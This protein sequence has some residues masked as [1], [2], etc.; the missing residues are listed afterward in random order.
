MFLKVQSSS[1]FPHTTKKPWKVDHN[2]I[3]KC[4][5]VLKKK[6]D[7]AHLYNRCQTRDEWK[8]E[9][10]FYISQ[11]GPME[12]YKVPSNHMDLCEC[13][14]ALKEI[15]RKEKLKRDRFKSKKVCQ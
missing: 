7:L 3:C 11:N 1:W 10:D 14:V 12:Y 4:C 9:R 13:C 2:E 6:K 15:R 5:G 8:K